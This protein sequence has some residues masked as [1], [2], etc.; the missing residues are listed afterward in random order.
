MMLES[1]G[2][3]GLMKSIIMN[4]IFVVVIYGGYFIL[5]YLCSKNII[6]ED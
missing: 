6:K 2:R 4:S 3:D 5:T 1:F